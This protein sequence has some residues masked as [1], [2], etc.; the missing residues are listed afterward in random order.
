VAPVP[1]DDARLQRALAR[2]FVIGTDRTAQQ[3]V[4]FPAQQL[5]EVALRAL[6]PGV[7]EPFTAMTCIERIG[8]AFTKLARRTI[9]SALRVDDAGRLRVVAEPQRFDRLLERTYGPIALYADRN[10][11]ISECLLRTLH[12]VAEV[13]RR[14]GD[15]EAIGRMADVVLQV[16]V[17][18]VEDRRRRAEL[19]QLHADVRRAVV[20]RVPE[21]WRQRRAP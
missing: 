6:S 2:T 5:V 12:H 11:D 19:E 13:A 7:N 4:G 20:E 17:P 21:T 10:P 15:R 14:A 8:Q 9:P 16:A 1:S 3:D 18:R